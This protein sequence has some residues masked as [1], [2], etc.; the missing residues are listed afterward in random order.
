MSG[1]RRCARVLSD[2]AAHIN[3]L[4]NT[5]F[6]ALIH[7][8]LTAREANKE[9]Q[10]TDSKQKNEMLFTRFKTNYNNLPAYFRKGSTLARVD[11]NPMPVTL[12]PDVS[13]DVAADSATSG[14]QTPV[15]TD[16]D[17]DDASAQPR[18]AGG[19]AIPAKRL[20]KRK[21]YEGTTGEIVTMHEDI[22]RNPF[23]RARP[24]LLA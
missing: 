16:A 15:T 21:P 9:L 24:W 2:N 4:Y 7:D 5:C 12:E 6:W 14:V 10:G 23:W 20:A 13:D 3:N 17:E 22:I 19:S 18:G 11:P 1:G 8:G